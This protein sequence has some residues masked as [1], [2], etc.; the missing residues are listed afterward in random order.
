M[1]IEGSGK[2]SG[3]FVE[4]PKGNMRSDVAVESP[5]LSTSLED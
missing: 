5:H 4:S 2:V 1:V 3:P